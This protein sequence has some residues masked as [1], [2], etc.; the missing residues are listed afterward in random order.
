MAVT[1]YSS[2]V[3]VVSVTDS[4][5]SGAYTQNHA[6]PVF[7]QRWLFYLVVV[8][9]G[10]A[11]LGYQMVWSRMLAVAL[12]H[13]VV[14]V[15][16]VVAAFF[17]GLALGGFLLNKNIRQS[18][19]PQLWY[20][21]LELVIALWALVLIAVV[22]LYN[23]WM[24]QLM[25]AE[26]SVFWQWF[27][28][29][30]GTFVLLLPATAAMGATLPAVE[31]VSKLHC[32]ER[33]HV[34][35]LYALNTLGAVV[36]TLLSTFFLI[37]FFGLK[38]TL[39]V[40]ALCNSLC[41]ATIYF[42]EKTTR[43]DAQAPPV[44]TMPAIPSL[45]LL[46][47]LFFSGLLGIG[48][49]VLMVRLLSQ[50]L[51]NTVY[52]FAAVLSV[53][54]MGTALGAAMYQRYCHFFNFS[55]SRWHLGYSGLLAAT[56][57]SCMLGFLCLYLCAGVY[58]SLWQGL[59]YDLAAAFVAEM[60]VA[61]LVF[62]LPTLS[63]GAL[64]SHLA[65][66]ASHQF[67]LGRAM[68]INTLG[69]ALA[70]AVFGIVLLPWL[71]A[72]LA[73]VLVA[74]AYLLLFSVS[75]KALKDRQRWLAL[76]ILAVLIFAFL[77][78]SFRFIQTPDNGKIVDYREGVMAAVA[79]V[80]DGAG[81]RH[82]KVNN[83]FTMGGTASRLS[84][85]RQ[86]HIPLLLHGA[87]GSVLYLGLGT[88]I[89]FEAAQ[90]YPAMEVVGVDL[91]PEVLQTL[92][93]F[94]TDPE[95]TYWPQPP[96]LLA[97]DARRYVLASNNHFDVIIGEIFH[98]SRD[99]AGS[100]YTAEHFSA[101]KVRL[102]DDGLFCQWLPLFQLDIDNLKVIVRTFLTVFPYAEMHLGHLSLGQPILCLAGRKQAAVYADDWLLVRVPE[103]RL[104][105]ELIAA[106]LNSDYSL[107]GG[108]LADKNALREFA[109]TG[110][111]N[112]DDFPM[113]NYRA[114]Y[115]VYSDALAPVERLLQLIDFFEDYSLPA[116]QFRDQELRERLSHYRTARDEF[117]RVGQNYPP[118][119]KIHQW[120]ISVASALLPVVA[121]SGDFYPAYRTLLTAAQTIYEV[122]PQK[123]YRVLQELDR[124]R[125]EYPEARQLA[126]QLF[127]GG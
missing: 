2:Q 76:P 45:V 72:K 125:P 6:E 61:L 97:A 121:E 48:Y 19:R 92:K 95:G 18:Q 11:G 30:A 3:K 50:I 21:A 38:T 13:E 34:P 124:L 105:R 75:W 17:I 26:P 104:Q 88:G 66:V 52:T 81:E 51:E 119:E 37:Q 117:I 108:F 93:F 24:P 60:I 15:L 8:F 49:E 12:G 120:A 22:P 99:G 79:V 40:L 29:F 9:S 118:G 83:H 70:P 57:L 68:A 35:I 32:P 102:N 63:M 106:R 33:Q 96:H 100:L 36:G 4:E 114:P 87:P 46:T 16:A 90:Y 25:G 69:S 116:E 112:T 73:L 74:M 42:S 1:K 65:S 77:P 58:E 47:L 82:L 53:Y 23:T 67:G 54:L 7:A 44:I 85:H 71:G 5:L 103:E 122:S 39:V 59:G 98:P 109:G 127:G 126:Q 107:F 62:F 115:F 78:L 43:V 94:N 10:F 89:T 84:D 20:V 113:V 31:R 28:A 80:E 101:I 41:A 91:I 14:A 86:T 55:T 64:F 27:L 123:A 110:P 56:L 111:L